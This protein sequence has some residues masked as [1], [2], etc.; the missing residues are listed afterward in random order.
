MADI[1][2]EELGRIEQE[3]HSDTGSIKTIKEFVKPEDLYAELIAG[4]RKYHPSADISLM[5]KH[6]RLHMQ[7]MMDKCVNREKLIL[8]IRCV[9]QSFLQNLSWIRRRLPQDY[10]TMFSKIPL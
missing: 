2:T 1:S 3:F 8:Y 7:H 4:I 9:L 10:C 5:K 6:T